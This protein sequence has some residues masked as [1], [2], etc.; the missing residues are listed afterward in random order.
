MDQ[1][2][3]LTEPS[4]HDQQ[5]QQQDFSFDD[6]FSIQ[7]HQQM[8]NQ[9]QQQQQIKR[10]DDGVDDSGICMNFMDD[11]LNFAKFGMAGG[12]IGHEYATGEINVI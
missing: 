8:S 5:H 6:S 4:Q 10:H 7:P 2:F 3:Q 1:H 12:H 9:Q 11:D